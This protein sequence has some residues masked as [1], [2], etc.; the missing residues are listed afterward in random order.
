MVGNNL[1]RGKGVFFLYNSSIACQQGFGQALESRRDF[2][3]KNKSAPVLLDQG[4][5]SVQNLLPTTVVAENR[6]GLKR[7]SKLIYEL[8]KAFFIGSLETVNGLVIVAYHKYIGI[9]WIV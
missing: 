9:F 4:T 7:V 5:C 8:F 2:A 6:K 3:I 1:H